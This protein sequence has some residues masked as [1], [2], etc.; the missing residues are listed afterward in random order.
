M[1]GWNI[2]TTKNV[3]HIQIVNLHPTLQKN[4]M[5]ALN[6]LLV[7]FNK[8]QN[9]LHQEMHENITAFPTP[10]T[11]SNNIASLEYC[12]PKQSHGIHFNIIMKNVPPSFSTECCRKHRNQ[13][14]THNMQQTKLNKKSKRN[15]T[16]HH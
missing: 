12:K 15:S 3:C 6:I 9:L 5:K 2:N 16:N 7:K 8:S 4:K 10:H 13:P 11:S 14:I 1:L